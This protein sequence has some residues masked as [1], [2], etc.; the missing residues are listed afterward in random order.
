MHVLPGLSS[1]LLVLLS[2]YALLH[3]LRFLHDWTQRRV[4]QFIALLM[5]FISLGIG[6]LHFLLNLGSLTASSSWGELFGIIFPL[7]MLAAVCGAVCWGMVR[8]LFM[9]WLV[10]R[11]GFAADADL[12]MLMTRL[13]RR[14]NVRCPRLLL[15]VYR[16]P[17]A[18]TSGV[19]RPT[20]LLS[21]WMLEQLDRHELEAVLAHELKHVARKDYLLVLLA[22]VLRDA[23][24]YLPTSWIVYR[25][26][27]QEKELV[28]DDLAVEVTQRPLALAS[29]LT[30]V[31]L[32]A[33]DTPAFARLGGAQM[34]TR[35]NTLI[36]TRIQRLMNKHAAAA[37]VQPTPLMTLHTSIAALLA[38]QVAQGVNFIFV[39]ALAGCLPFTFA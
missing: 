8:W 25:Q 23:F 28:C 16:R 19:F 13:C 9:H 33:V 12:Q 27:Q 11:R 20:I 36:H 37:Q 14:L 15:C 39:L 26:L 22:T 7:C 5:P 24:F 29:A 34:L 18:L 2:G 38:L 3:M 32:H 31:W 30:K 6:G 35:A 10:A 4:T 21:T 1:I 17:L